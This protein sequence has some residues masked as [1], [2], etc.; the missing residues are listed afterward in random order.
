MKRSRER[1]VTCTDRG[2]SRAL[3][4]PVAHG[5]LLAVLIVFGPSRAVFGEEGAPSES[6]CLELEREANG[7]PDPELIEWDEV[8]G[9]FFPM[10]TARLMLCEV[11]ELRLRRREVSV[12]LSLIETW[13]HQVEVTT[14]QRDLA[15]EARD[16]LE[17]VIERAERQAHEAEDRAEAWYRSPW[18]LIS[19]G[20]VLTVG[21]YVAASYGLRALAPD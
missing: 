14:R 8:R 15:V 12:D 16:E 20:V 1:S 11:R 13:R 5:V 6:H 10:V 2:L 19:L 9:M 7:A 21:L 17:Q 3:R 18:F 4:G